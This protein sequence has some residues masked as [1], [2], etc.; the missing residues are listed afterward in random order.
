MPLWV[1]RFHWKKTPTVLVDTEGGLYLRQEDLA[2]IG[3]L[4]LNDGMWNDRRILPEQWV[5][6]TMRPAAEVPYW[7]ARYGFQWWLLPYAGGSQDWAYAGI[8]YGG[9]RLLVVPE[10]DLVAVFTGWN[11]D[12]IPALDPRFALERVLSSVR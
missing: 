5:A 10:Y 4:Y 11:I 2:K 8:G 3:Y 9:Q 1:D 7:D 6:E 12:D